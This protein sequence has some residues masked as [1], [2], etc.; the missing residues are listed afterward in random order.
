MEQPLQPRMRPSTR[1]TSFEGWDY[2]GMKE[3]LET[4]LAGLNKDVLLSYA[5]LLKSQK[6]SMSDKFSAGQY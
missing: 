4:A 5:E 6:L 1:W 2:Y 3:R